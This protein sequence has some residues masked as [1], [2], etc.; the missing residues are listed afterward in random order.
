MW[1]RTGKSK[2]PYYFQIQNEEPFAFAGIWDEWRN[3]GVSITSCSIITT[4]PNELLA[5][6]HE[7]RLSSRTKLKMP[8]FIVIPRQANWRAF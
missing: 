1:K 8:G 6:I 2:Q 4:T 7:C 3:D 5:T